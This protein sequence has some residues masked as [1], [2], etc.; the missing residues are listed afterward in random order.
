[1]YSTG[2][3][4]EESLQFQLEDSTESRVTDKH[5]IKQELFLLL[6]EKKICC[7]INVI[8]QHFLRHCII[9][10]APT[11]SS[12]FPIKMEWNQIWQKKT[13]SF[14]LKISLRKASIKNFVSQGLIFAKQKSWKVF[15]RFSSSSRSDRSPSTRYSIPGHPVYNS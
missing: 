8:L 9:Y 3:K 14:W 1:M 10:Y 2:C 7:A 12:L 5:A 15:S 13:S 4:K 6:R 11:E